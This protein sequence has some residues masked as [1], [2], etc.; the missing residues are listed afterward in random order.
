MAT[1]ADLIGYVRRRLGEPN[2][3]V[4]LDDSQIDDAIDDALIMFR[5]WSH[6]GVYDS[7]YVISTVANQSTYTL[8]A[9]IQEVKKVMTA[10]FSRALTTNIIDP[11]LNIF[12]PANQ[13][14][15]LV[16]IGTEYL[17]DVQRMF[18]T[19]YNFSTYRDPTNQLILELTPPPR[20]VM[21]LGL[22]VTKYIDEAALLGTR[23]IRQYVYA[24]SMKMLAEVRGKYAQLAGPNGPQL[25]GDRLSSDAD[26]LLEKLENEIQTKHYRPIGLIQG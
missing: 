7:T 6:S 3:K 17:S 13:G 2:V 4:E 10:S 1:R 25:N 24:L 16:E 5:E 9:E 15:S 19:A 21:K 14:Y 18:E 8:P 11:Y 20:R 22:M 12:G 23:W 26:A